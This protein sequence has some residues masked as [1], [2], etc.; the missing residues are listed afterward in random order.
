MGQLDG[1]GKMKFYDQMNKNEARSK[2]LLE[3]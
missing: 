1:I 3:E 2:I